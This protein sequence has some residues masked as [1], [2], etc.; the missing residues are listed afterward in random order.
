MKS[1]IVFLFVIGLAWVTTAWVCPIGEEHPGVPYGN[2]N[3]GILNPNGTIQP[4]KSIRYCRPR[5]A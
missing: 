2:G 4:G 3:Y 5:L 1:S